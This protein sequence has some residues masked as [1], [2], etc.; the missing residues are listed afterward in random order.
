M[1]CS[2]LHDSFH[3]Q[4]NS[5]YIHPHLSTESLLL[6]K[7]LILYAEVQIVHAGQNFT[8]RRTYLLHEDHVQYCEHTSTKTVYGV[9]HQETIRSTITQ[10][11]YILLHTIS[12]SNSALNVTS[13]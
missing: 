8:H 6:D 13:H 9:M 3:K 2:L 11:P 10:R 4:Y 5:I 1:T 12:D 7:V